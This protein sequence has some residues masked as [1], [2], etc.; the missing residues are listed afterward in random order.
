[1]FLFFVS[2]LKIPFFSFLP[3]QASPKTTRDTSGGNG[4]GNSEATSENGPLTPP[5]TT[6][7]PPTPVTSA[8]ASTSNSTSTS[9]TKS[10]STSSTTTSST[11]KSPPGYDKRSFTLI[12]AF[13]YLPHPLTKDT[14]QCTDFVYIR[15][16]VYS[17]QTNKEPIVFEKKKRFDGVA[18]LYY[19]DTAE[20]WRR[21][22]SYRTLDNNVKNS[23][24]HFPYSRW[25]L[26]IW[27]TTFTR[28]VASLWDAT[29]FQTALHDTLRSNFSDKLTIDFFNG[30]AIINSMI[31]DSR[32]MGRA[33]PF[34]KAF[35]AASNPILDPSWAYIHTAGHLAGRQRARP[36]VDGGRHAQSKGVTTSERLF[37]HRSAVSC[38]Y[39]CAEM[40]M[41]SGLARATPPTSPNIILE[42]AGP[43]TAPYKAASPPN[44]IRPVALG[45]RGMLEI[46]AD[47]P[48]WKTVLKRASLCFSLSTSINYMRSSADPIDFV[49][50]VHN[51][52][53]VQRY[54]RL[55]FTTKVN[56]TGVYPVEEKQT[57][58][59]FDNVT[60]SHIW[61]F[62]R[63]HDILTLFAY[64]TN[65]TMAYKANAMLDAY[66][67]DKCI[68]FEDIGEDY[69]QAGFS[70]A[71]QHVFFGKMDMIKAV[72][73]VM[74]KKYG[75]PFP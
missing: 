48:H 7:T 73:D 8:N 1:F 37:S 70:Y 29:A 51:A 74:V 14:P 42:R 36:R 49:S 32:T 15:F 66:G 56:G 33:E 18:K 3:P 50:E 38:L 59:H 23:K 44:P 4:T 71:N 46:L 55:R 17:Y 19:D 68:V 40:P 69:E 31:I 9:T 21:F 75:V 25:F 22:G 5:L 20:L 34:G 6:D 47:F 30:F 63:N 11:T 28:L 2:G 43:N 35:R 54:H 52:Q 26:G 41:W 10:G 16:F 64:D 27:G 58:Y 13:E 60:Y 57:T 45:T 62:D 61:R 24:R 72:Y 65:T 12:C 53:D 39:T 67:Q